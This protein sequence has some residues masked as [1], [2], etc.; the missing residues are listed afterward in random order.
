[1]DGGTVKSFNPDKGFGFVVGPDGTDVFLHRKSCADNS[2]PQKGDVVTFDMEP[3]TTK[4]GQFQA[5]NVTGGTG[6]AGG[7][8]PV[9]GTGA[10]RGTCKSFSAQSEYGFIVGE[11]GSDIFLHQRA[12]VDGSTPKQGDTLQY[13]LEPSR[14]R[15]DKMQATNVTGGTGKGGGYGK[16]GW[17]AK[18]GGKGGPYGKGGWCGKGMDMGWGGWG[19]KGMPMMG[20]GGWGGKGWWHWPGTVVVAVLAYRQGTADRARLLAARAARVIESPPGTGAAAAAGPERE[21]GGGL[22]VDVAETCSGP[23]AV[24]GGAS[25]SARSPLRA[26]APDFRRLPLTPGRL[27]LGPERLL[28]PPPPPACAQAAPEP[29][30]LSERSRSPTP[31]GRA[32]DGA[33]GAQAAPPLQPLVESDAAAPTRQAVSPPAWISPPRPPMPALPGQMPSQPSSPQ[34]APPAGPAASRGSGI[35]PASLRLDLSR[36]A[37]GRAPLPEALRR[38]AS[39]SG[40][41]SSSSSRSGSLS[42]CRTPPLQPS[43]EPRGP[44]G[45]PPDELDDALARLELGPEPPAEEPLALPLGDRDGRGPQDD[46][47]ADQLID[48]PETT[49]WT[50]GRYLKHK[51]RRRLLE[52]CGGGSSGTKDSSRGCVSVLGCVLVNLG[53]LLF[54]GYRAHGPG[55]ARARAGEGEIVVSEDSGPRCAGV[56]GCWAAAPRSATAP[57]SPALTAACRSRKT[58][59]SLPTS[60]TRRRGSRR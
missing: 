53:F 25:R 26:V 52:I 8:T 46:R 45:P 55:S 15:P 16:S 17:G 47:L 60:L 38:G 9:E 30:P 34:P 50:F 1:M 20:W 28:P 13:D 22:T 19:G 59:P 5:V 6:S 40:S 31:R 24:W 44:K 57:A 21:T 36:V 14:S 56:G 27:E 43:P 41:A 10:H 33:G 54:F 32:R 3:S 49:Q 11:D 37:A 12:M 58:T 7:G 51:Q 23:P 35:D 39:P 29:P 4:P 2:V 48:E 18:G 42:S